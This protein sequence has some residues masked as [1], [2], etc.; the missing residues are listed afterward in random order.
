VLRKPFSLLFRAA[1]CVV[2]L[3]LLMLGGCGG[4]Q[5]LKT[6][7]PEGHWEQLAEKSKG[8]S[9]SPRKK[10]IS[11]SDYRK[12]LDTEKAQ[13]DERALPTQKISLKMRNAD[14]KSILRA[15]ARSVNVNLLLRDEVK[16]V[17][18]VDFT[19]VP[20]NQAFVNLLNAYGLTYAWEGD[21][22]RVMSSDD[23]ESAVKT[24]TLKGKMKAQELA[25]K[26]SEPFST[27]VIPI[28]YADPKSLSANLQEFL[29]K[30]SGAAGAA[31]GAA[32]GTRG[33]IKVDEHSN[34]LIIQAP[35]DDIERIVALIEKI[36][37]PTPQILIRANI[38]E[39]T[40]DVARNLG[41]QWGGILKTRMNQD[42][43]W[44]TPGGTASAGS[45]TSSVYSGSYSPTSGATG[46]SGQGYGLNFPVGAD[47]I[48]SAGGV[49]AI[50]LMV[51]KLGG[52]ILDLQLQALQT[53]GKAN[54]IS[55]P[56]LTTLDNQKA[57]TESG[58]KVPYVATQTTSGA[59][60]QTVNFVDAVLRLEITPHVID[61]KNLKMA[62]MLKKDDVD[63]TRSVQGNPFIVKK[64]TETTLIVE[65]GETI[66]ISGLSSQNITNH[67]K[68]VPGL[69]DIPG[70]GWL[71]KGESKG[72]TTDEVLIFITPYILPTKT[73]EQR[74]TPKAGG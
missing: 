55:S 34:S 23:L 33:S 26:Y 73:A 60:T 63:T 27:V 69:K 47:K 1:L 57:F 30:D 54:I 67:V 24:E 22:L 62:I 32:K 29:S 43:V 16:G 35:R 25:T 42:T 61:G 18:T 66:V 56:S 15:L 58:T 17:T 71:F 6:T 49:G 31:G 8:Y 50:G 5:P 64:Q 37:K 14:I 51:G 20:W 7:M 12:Q 44:I 52:N 53:D 4:T 21:V 9:P 19:G 11:I 39:T 28:D 2:V 72:E 41:I 36:D 13:K 10:E 70:L 46:I 45:T 74:D 3:L 68:G 40:K 38:V 59:T 48:Q 65:D